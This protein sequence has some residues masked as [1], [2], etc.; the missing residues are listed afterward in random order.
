ML[1]DLEESEL[2]DSWPMGIFGGHR[3]VSFRMGETRLIGRLDPVSGTW[4]G[5]NAPDPEG[6]VERIELE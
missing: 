1:G 4:L 2:I 5:R 6:R 3:E